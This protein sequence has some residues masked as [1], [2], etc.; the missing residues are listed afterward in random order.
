MSE[1][2][3]LEKLSVGLVR[4]REEAVSF[5]DDLLVYLLNMAVSHVGKKSFSL[6][7]AAEETNLAQLGLK[8]ATT[9]VHY[10]P[11]GPTETILTTLFTALCQ[12]GNE[13]DGDGAKRGV[14]DSKKSAYQT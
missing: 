5:G 10:L 7:K 13:I 8:P 14:A 12:F 11:T 6:R 4:V 1:L 3:A 2:E 9:Q